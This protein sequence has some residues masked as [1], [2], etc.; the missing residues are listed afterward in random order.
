MFVEA[1]VDGILTAEA[2]DPIEE[3]ATETEL[4]DELALATELTL[5]TEL[6]LD[7]DLTLATELTLAMELAMA[8]ELALAAE[9][10]LITLAG[11]DVAVAD[12]G[13]ASDVIVKG[14]GVAVELQKYD[15]KY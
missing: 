11:N 14:V 5:A 1:V 10:R 8:T 12:D 3:T 15:A 4:D 6:I 9:L 13:A 2:M 7:T